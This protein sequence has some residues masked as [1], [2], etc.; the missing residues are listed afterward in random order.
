MKNRKENHLA[1]RTL[2]LAVHGALVAMCAMPLGALAEGEANDDLI[3][4][5]L[6]HNYVEIGAS[7]TSDRSEKFG[8]YNDLYESGAD[9]IA[10]FSYSGGNAYAKPDG[11]VTEDGTMRWNVRGV[12]LGTRSRELSANIANQGTWNIGVGFDSLRHLTTDTYQTPLVGSVGSN[13]FTLPTNFGLANTNTA[14]V[15]GPG[16]QGLTATQRGLFHDV[17]VYTDRENKTVTVGYNFNPQWRVQ[18]DYNRLDQDG[19]KVIGSATE[20]RFNGSLLAASGATNFAGQGIMYVLTP[21][22]FTTDTVNL[23]L[24]W[25]GDRANLSASYFGSF[26]RDDNSGFSWQSPIVSNNIAAGTAP[27]T[28]YGP[29]Q[30]ST[31]PDNRLHQFNLTGGYNFRPT[32]RL[33]AGFSYGRNT[34]DDTFLRNS[35]DTTLLPRTSFDGK[36]DTWHFDT[37]LTDQSIKNLSLSAAFKFNERENRSSSNDYQW[38]NVGSTGSTATETNTPYSKRTYAV[39]LAADYRVTERNKVKLSYG[40]EKLERWCEHVASGEECVRTP[41]SHENKVGVGYRLKATDVVTFKADY[42]Y[43]SRDSKSNGFYEETIGADKVGFLPFFDAS[44]NQHLV[45]LGL[46]ADVTDKFS[47]SASARRGLDTY[48]DGTRGTR[49]GNTNGYNLDASYSYSEKGVVSAYLS[50]DFRERNMTN[51]QSSTTANATRIAVPSLGTWSN[52]L[53]DESTVIGVNVKHGGLLGGKLEL[54]G[55]ASYSVGQTS[56]DTQFNYTGVDSSGRGCTNAFYLTCGKTPDIANRFFDLKLSGAYK[57]DKHSKIGAGY[58]FSH[59]T[60]DDYYY[61]GLQLG[62]TPTS[63]LP[64][65]QKEPSYTVHF[66]RATYTYSF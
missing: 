13:R 6:P 17:D 9:A 28:V 25:V 22:N 50:T 56:Y 57:V 18:L 52:K 26:F 32:T 23:A 2:T 19:S 37:K 20:A 21:T 8:E 62:Y 58:V 30:M 29:N 63:L 34:Q 11:T 7:Y 14:N 47:L 39:D 42:S 44:R 16:L 38:Y 53:Q 12:D 41:D 3:N 64:T 43:N 10:N 55:D 61:N 49:D 31:A 45:K 36:V 5:V 54:E 59:L 15:L 33:T 40:Y 60:S 66:F 46:T 1:V 27:A 4:L 35:I 24:H 65:N 51:E 48:T